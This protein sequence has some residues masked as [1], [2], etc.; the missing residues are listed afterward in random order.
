MTF[1]PPT[2]VELGRYLVAHGAVNLGIVGDTAHAAKG[3][4]YHLGKDQLTADA[5][6]AKLPRDKAGLSNAASAI[7]IGAVNGSL[8]GLQRLSSW[9]VDAC[10]NEQ[11]DTEDIRE[12]IYSPD[13]SGVFRWDNAAKK[14]YTAGT[15]TGQGD[16]SHRSHTHV[17]YYRDSESHDKVALYARYFEEDEVDPTEDLPIAICDFDPGATLYADRDRRTVLAANW[18]GGEKVGIYTMPKNPVQSDGR[19]ALVA[20]RWDSKGGPP[21]KL[22][23]AWGGVDKVGNIRLPNA[24]DPT[25]LGPGIYEVG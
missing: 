21:E 25:P 9:L 19:A 18:I 14:A 11:P 5:Y 23:V 17:S 12:V 8:Q 6:S 3:T 16:D 1:A 7:D 4:S 20:I 22:H 13:G 10:I 2:L 15:G 24:P